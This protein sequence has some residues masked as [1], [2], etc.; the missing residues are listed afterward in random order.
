MNA[1]AI[2][3]LERTGHSKARMADLSDDQKDRLSELSTSADIRL[4][5]EE[6]LSGTPR[7]TVA[8]SKMKPAAK[9]K[10]LATSNDGK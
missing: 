6:I 4:A 1:Q 2:F 8:E 7:A 10:K 3:A 9:P 5:V